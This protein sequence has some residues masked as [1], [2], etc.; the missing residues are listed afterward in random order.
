MIGSCLPRC[1]MAL[2]SFTR[3]A[4]TK[5]PFSS[6]KGKHVGLWLKSLQHAGGSC[7]RWA[8]AIGSALTFPRTRTILRLWFPRVRFF[9]LCRNPTNWKNPALFLV[10]DS[11]I[12]SWGHF[13]MWFSCQ[14]R[15]PLSVETERAFRRSCGWRIRGI[16]VDSSPKQQGSVLRSSF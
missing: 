5:P 8:C 3:T 15:R 9:D 1:G 11:Q 12:K 13:L 6:P 10:Q 14:T 4:R 7:R 16:H 2:A